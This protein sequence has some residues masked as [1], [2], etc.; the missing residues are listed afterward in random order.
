M[1]CPTAPCYNQVLEIVNLRNS[2]LI[3]RKDE[4]EIVHGLLLELVDDLKGGIVLVK[5]EPGV[6][7]SHFLSCV[8]KP[9][10][11]VQSCLFFRGRAIQELKNQ[12]ISLTLRE[13]QFQV[14]QAE[15]FNA[16]GSIIIKLISMFREGIL[17]PE[18]GEA[19][20]ITQTQLLRSAYTKVREW[21][22]S[23]C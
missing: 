6:G 15:G 20:S 9:A 23:A 10:N 1:Y 13:E 8:L 5:G 3:G 22:A 12:L 21:R 16:W 18:K 19:W 7:K 4:S 11:R 17:T 14:A 2:D